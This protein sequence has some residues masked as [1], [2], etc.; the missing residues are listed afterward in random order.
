MRG[1][2]VAVSVTAVLIAPQL[3][4]QGNQREEQEVVVPESALPPAGM[5]RVWLR[6]VPERQQPAPTDCAT[7]LRTRPRT[8]ILLFGDLSTEAKQ[9]PIRAQVSSP[10]GTSARSMFDEPLGR[11]ALLRA[12]DLRVMTGTMSPSQAMRAA[13][14]LRAAQG[15]AQGTAPGTEVGKAADQTKAAA[16]KRPDPPPPRH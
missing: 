12:V 2:I 6:D 11:N 14:A 3:A 4:A 5:C 16:V 7:A 10:I 15:T 1:S 8:A 13:E 9:P